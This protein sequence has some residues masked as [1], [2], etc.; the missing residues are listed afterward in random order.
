[1]QWDLSRQEKPIVEQTEQELQQREIDAARKEFSPDGTVY[2]V[3]YSR[4]ANAFDEKKTIVKDPHGKLLFE[5]KE[6]DIPYSFIQWY[7]KTKNSYTRSNIDQRYLNELNLIGGEFSRHFVIP[8]ANPQ[9]T[10]IGHWFFDTDNQIFK[11]YGVAGQQL[12]YIGA[13]GYTEIKSETVGFEECERM[14]SWLRPNS[15]DS[16]MFYQTQYALYQIDFQ[17]KQV[18]TLVKTDN[19][20]I[21][22]MV[23]NNWQE[24]EAYDYRP[25]LAIFTKSNKFYLYLKNPEQ[26]IESQLP[27]DF[28]YLIAPQFAADE[29]TIYALLHETPE[30]PKTTDINLY[31]D[32]RQEN[33]HKPLGHRA[34]LFEVDKTGSFLEKSSFAWTQPARPPNVAMR[35][36][37]ETVFHLTNSLS[38]PVP[39]WATY[40]WLKTGVHRQWSGW[41]H[42][43]MSFIQAYSSFKIFINLCVMAVFAALAFL[44]GWPRRTHIAKLIFWTVFVFL[45]NLPG[46][47]TYLALNH[48]PVIQCANCGKKRGLLQD[49]CCRCGT[50]LALPK[51]KETDLV[52]PLSA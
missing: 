51:A 44:H 34:R 5:G 46:F 15:F 18:D 38:S 33:R 41:G 3:S 17:N 7:S 16:I 8:M 45:F 2:L 36:S 1:D 32:W 30:A 9:N 26:V 27:S 49:A 48:T 43:I 10:R 25:S 19:D 21:R 29:K 40:H 4:T 31:L 13:N 11:Y 47:L 39:L 22:R 24:A 6:E 50:A 23:M 20:P 37:R 42:V 14:E 28:G 35:S 12:G 52:M